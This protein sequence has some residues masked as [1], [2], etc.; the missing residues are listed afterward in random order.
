MARPT[1]YRGLEDN[2]VSDNEDV[3]LDFFKT[4]TNVS[5][6][7]EEPETILKEQVHNGNTKLFDQVERVITFGSH[8]DL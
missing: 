6:E 4:K 1:C 5:E 3:N 7:A 2:M 8:L